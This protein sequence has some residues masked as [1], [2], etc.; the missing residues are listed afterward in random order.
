MISSILRWPSEIDYSSLDSRDSHFRHGFNDLSNG[1]PIQNYQFKR[2][3]VNEQLPEWLVNFE[4]NRFKVALSL[5]FLDSRTLPAN[6]RKLL[7]LERNF[8]GGSKAVTNP[9]HFPKRTDPL[10]YLASQCPSSEEYLLGNHSRMEIQTIRRNDISFELLTCLVA[11]THGLAAGLCF[12]TTEFS[13]G[14]VF[15]KDIWYVLKGGSQE[16]RRTMSAMIDYM[17]IANNMASNIGTGVSTP[18]D[19]LYSEQHDPIITPHLI[20]WVNAGGV[21]APTRA[22]YQDTSSAISDY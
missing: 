5:S 10:K 13:N 22:L 18:F 19:P 2:H 7:G 20:S 12:E 15:I 1:G 6:L 21:W 16:G 3:L 8:S 17:D 14:V 9:P 4:R 11:K